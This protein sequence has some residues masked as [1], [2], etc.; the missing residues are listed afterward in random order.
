MTIIHDDILNDLRYRAVYA[1]ESPFRNK[2]W[3]DNGLTIFINE[4][5][6]FVHLYNILGETNWD[7]V[8]K[9]LLCVGA[10][11][12]IYYSEGELCIMFPTPA[13][14]YRFIQDMNAIMESE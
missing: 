9:V 10:I 13:S 4:T 11:M 6:N 1:P 12:E 2:R 3:V 8:T 5:V 14:K 7:N